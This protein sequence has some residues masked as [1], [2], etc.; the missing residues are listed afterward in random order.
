[1]AST[2]RAALTCTLTYGSGGDLLPIANTDVTVITRSGSSP[3]TIWNA[4]SGGST[5][6]GN[7]ISTDATGNLNG[8]TYSYFLAEGSYI[9]QVAGTGSYGAFVV[10]YEAVHGDGVGNLAPA[11]LAGD[12]TLNGS[13]A[14]VVN[15]VQGG[16]TPLTGSE[17]TV[18]VSGDLKASAVSSVPT[19]WLLCNNQ[20]VSR[21]TYANLFAAIGTT[22]GS[23]DG[24]TT[25]N[26]P[27]LRGRAPIGSGAS[28]ATYGSTWALGETPSGASV[29]GGEEQHSL[30]YAENGTHSHGY[31]GTTGLG[32]AA[33]QYNY[34]NNDSG[35]NVFAKIPAGN[36]PVVSNG[37][38]GGGSNIS[39]RA[40]SG[41][42][43][44]GSTNLFHAHND[45]GHQHN[46]S[47]GTDTGG[48]AGNPHNIMQPI[49]VVN[50]FIK[51]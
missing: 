23:G 26:V 30:Y 31:S 48:S 37:L 16:L 24:S 1:M 7:S 12:V 49:C 19:G 4:A 10:Y 18:F 22:Y 21:T 42:S 41:T 2:Q 25:F 11:L 50:W 13:G 27:D 28:S 40:S 29:A 17:T 3:A 46:Y 9:I 6:A 15:T 45:A 33:L 51:T 32:Y 14:L 5:Y 8:S 20:A 43:P 34:A 44:W 47:G 36:G 39:P 35:T 38:A